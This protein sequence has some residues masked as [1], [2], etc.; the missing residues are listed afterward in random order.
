RSVGTGSSG[1]EVACHMLLTGRLELPAGFNVNTVPNANEWPSLPALVTYLTK[2]RNNLPPAI[3]LP[4]PSI[5]ESGRARP[6]QFAGRLGPRWDAWHLNLASPCALGNGACPR[7]FRFDGTP[8]RHGSATIFDT[9]ALMLPDG[10]S[11]RLE[12]RVGLLRSIERQQR[13]L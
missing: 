8:F 9:P 4:Q 6:G 1:H 3:V 13:D 7:C 11:L 12:A 10:G 2:G 5:N